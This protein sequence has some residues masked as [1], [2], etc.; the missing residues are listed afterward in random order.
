M[1]AIQATAQGTG[2]TAPP[3]P[4]NLTEVSSDAILQIPGG[5]V[6]KL[7]ELLGRPVTAADA[8][9]LE[10]RGRQLSDHLL[11]AQQRRNEV[12][13]QYADAIDPAIRTGLEQ[14]LKVLDDRLSM[15]EQDIAANSRLRAAVPLS[16]GTT[17]EAPSVRS[18]SPIPG[19]SSGQFFV[20]NI[21]FIIFVV[22]PIAT[23]FAKRL[24]RKPTVL[25]IPQ[26]KEQSARIERI[27]QAVDAVAIEVERISE[28]QRFVTQ[29]LAKGDG[30]ARP[31][32]SS[33]T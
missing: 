19:L 29:L 3:Q 5:S 27:E 31:L 2:Q 1:N 7:E 30:A 26:L 8:R 4:A 10:T 33:D 24:W 32:V 15:I 9:A 23:S 14:R 22:A 20:L 11:S 6:I 28:G 13:E 17:E 12:A 25:P 18:V 21:L 16:V